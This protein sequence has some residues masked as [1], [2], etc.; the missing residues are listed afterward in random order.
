MTRRFHNAGT[1]PTP[2]ACLP[3][4][5]GRDEEV[6]FCLLVK[7][8]PHRILL[9]CGLSDPLR[10]F[11]GPPADWVLCTH[12]RPERAR[13]MLALHEAF[14]SLPIAA[15]EATA[16]LLP[17]N[18]PERDAISGF[19]RSLPWQVPIVCSD[20]LSIELFPAGFLPGAAAISLTYTAPDRPYRFFYTSDF[21]LSNSRLADGLSIES[22]RGL[23]PDVLV[24]EGYYGTA[25]HP[26]R[27]KQENRLVEQIA[28]WLESGRRV[29][30]PVDTFGSAQELLFLLRSHHQF[31]GRDLDI[32]A[33]EAIARVCDAYLE[34]LPFLPVT[35]QNFAHHQPLFWDERVGPRLQRFRDRPVAGDR[36]PDIVL[37]DRAGDWQR[38]CRNSPD[39]WVVLL[40]EQD[41][42]AR[43]VSPTWITATYLLAQHSDGLGTMQ[44]IH[45]L[46]PQH[47]VLIGGS[48]ANLA[49]LTAAEELQTRY[50]VHLPPAGQRVEL[51]V[52]K[53]FVQPAAPPERSYEGEVREGNN[54]IGI[55]LPA[56][57]AD[58]PRWH[59]FAET[60]I[61]SACWQGNTLV[62]HGLSQQDVLNIDTP[63][64]PHIASTRSCKTCRYFNNRRCRQPRSPLY[65]LQV[66]PEGYCLAY[67]PARAVD[68]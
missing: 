32:Y 33:E 57:L 35:V 23:T 52:G 43:T 16:S 41:P 40:P 49:D 30:L 42:I 5:V 1:L 48:A 8:G 50:H 63:E 47:V 58:D 66:P 68:A 26:H 46:R 4:A 17:L 55:V 13:G 44:L 51:P 60:G 22:V 7:M 34:V 59:N 64:Y 45:N 18:W 6:G 10:Y 62:L 2:L 21:F 67:A 36:R 31:T 20:D 38:Y 37:V 3:Y 54:R 61:V 19:C 12:A 27:R 29:L 56:A 39:E 15:S 25:R 53:T 9:D 11:N 65:T 28:T 24:V 14:P